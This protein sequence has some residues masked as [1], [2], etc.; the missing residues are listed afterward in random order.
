[1]THSGYQATLKTSVGV[2]DL[3]RHG[4]VEGGPCF[5]GSL[6]DPLTA[7]GKKIMESTLNKLAPCDQ[8]IT[9]PLIRC[10]QV[11]SKIAKQYS[12]PLK[13]E[14]GFSEICFGEWEGKS[15]SQILRYDSEPLKLFWQNPDI[16]SPPGGEK[17]SD[18]K[19]RVLVT[20]G[21]LSN[22]T[23]TKRKIIITHGGVIRAILAEIL[24][25]SLTASFALHVPLASVSRIHLKLDEHGRNIAP[26]L[27]FM[28]LRL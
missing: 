2:I 11:A 28:G 1:M 19:K 12:I 10:H 22:K 16:H 14:E 21:K 20:W 15:A 13:I 27:A 3:L 17:T 25:L 23:N 9:S 4:E 18:F 7:N 24:G 6:D 26:H 8:I 5:R